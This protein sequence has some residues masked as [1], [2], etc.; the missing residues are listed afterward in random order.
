MGAGMLAFPMGFKQAGYGLGVLLVLSFA[1]IQSASLSIIARCARNEGVRSYQDLVGRL[2]GDTAKL[3][4]MGA[5]SV[6]LF[7]VCVAY[8]TGAI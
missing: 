1:C 8:L 4:L 7:A 6:F 5:I 3:C 2:F